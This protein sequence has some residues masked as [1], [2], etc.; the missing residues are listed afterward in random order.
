MSYPPQQPENG[1]SDQQE[2]PVDPFAQGNAVHQPA[3]PQQPGQVYGQP[4]QQQPEYPQQP[5][6]GQQPPVYQAQPPVYYPEQQPGYPPSDQTQALPPRAAHDAPPAQPFPAAQPYPAQDANPQPPAAQPYYQPAEPNTAEQQGHFQQSPPAQP[7]YQ[8]VDPNAGQQQGYP[9]AQPLPDPFATQQPEQP[10]S[11]APVSA[12]PTSAE[13]YSAQPYSAQPASGQ[14]FSAQPY[15]PSA[16]GATPPGVPES[17]FAAAPT[18]NP[19]NTPAP[20]SAQPTS[21]GQPWGGS[22]S[23]PYFTPRK[24]RRGLPRWFYVV[25][26]IIVVAALGAGGYVWLGPGLGGEEPKD[27]AS[28][29]ATKDAD[30]SSEKPT[31]EKSEAEKQPDLVTDK[32]SG[33]GFVQLPKPWTEESDTKFPGFKDTTGQV[34]TN[35]GSVPGWF[36]AGEVDAKKIKYKGVDQLADSGAQLAGFI[37]DKHWTDAKGKQLKGAKRETKFKY[38]YI[39]IDGHRGVYLTYRMGWSSDKVKDKS[40]DVVVG[41]VDVGD[42]KA[43]GFFAVVPESL[44][45]KQKPAVEDTILSLRF[46]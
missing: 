46:E 5:E 7:Y 42:G 11:Q 34:L 38:N 22:P 45:D 33:L 37:D 39:R 40:A 44:S 1:W 28:A 10:F 20:V 18:H 8:P 24:P 32:G 17:P 9:Q 19:M 27:E 25:G 30:K 41:L 6:Q 13:P 26:V 2:E 16:A 21:G 14:P 43:A 15:S 31:E 36:V 29:S 23:T 3:A 12:S 4:I 35:K